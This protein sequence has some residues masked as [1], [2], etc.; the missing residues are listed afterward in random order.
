MRKELIPI[1]MKRTQ[2]KPLNNWSEIRFYKN[3][4]LE[5]YGAT[6]VTAT[7]RLDLVVTWMARDRRRRAGWCARPPA[8]LA[9]SWPL[10][11]LHGQRD[12]GHEAE[13]DVTTP[14]S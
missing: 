3:L 4:N 6:Q 2:S 12:A 14:E 1:L 8:R 5:L 13:G 7:T 9:S 10:R 11:P